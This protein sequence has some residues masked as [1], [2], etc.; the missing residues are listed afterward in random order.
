MKYLLKIAHNTIVSNAILAFY[1]F[2]VGFVLYFIYSKNI[3]RTS[4]EEIEKNNEIARLLKMVIK[5]THN[6]KALKRDSGQLISEVNK[7]KTKLENQKI[8]TSLNKDEMIKV[9]ISLEDK[10]NINPNVAKV[11]DAADPRRQR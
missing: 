1:V 6:I 3:S 5:Q 7:L 2:V 9:I 11:E 10:I 4:R 8:K